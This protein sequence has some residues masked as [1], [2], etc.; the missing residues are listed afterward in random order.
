MATIRTISATIGNAANNQCIK[1]RVES[2]GEAL[3]HAVEMNG[4]SAPRRRG[5]PA[6]LQGHAAS[7]GRVR[8]T[9]AAWRDSDGQV[10]ARIRAR[11]CGYSAVANHCRGGALNTQA[12]LRLMRHPGVAWPP[13]CLDA[14]QLRRRSNGPMA[15]HA[16]R[17][18][19]MWHGAW[20]CCPSFPMQDSAARFPDYWR[21]WRGVINCLLAASRPPLP[22]AANAA[23][24]DGCRYDNLKEEFR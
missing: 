5:L 10:I 12:L 17:L 23:G 7:R 1:P 22:D 3:L 9:G 13:A 24:N 8:S 6:G 20:Q 2:V 19:R 15:I 14:S 18:S 4:G 21:A 11:R 16:A